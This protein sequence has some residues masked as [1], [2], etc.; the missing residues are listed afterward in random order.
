VDWTQPAEVVARRIRGLSPFPGAWC[1]AGAERLKLLRARPVAGAGAPGEVLE[2][3]TAACGE[4]AVE[5]TQAQREGRRPM[6]AGEILRG[7]TLPPKLT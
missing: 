3:F 7:L 1:D 6:S 4:G 2:G 5:I